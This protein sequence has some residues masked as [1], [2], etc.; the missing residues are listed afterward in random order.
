MSEDF[1][2]LR[3]DILILGSGGAGLLAA[4]HAYDACD[5]LDITIVVKGMFGKSGCTRMVQGG[6]N[7]VLNPEDSFEKHFLDTVKG[8]GF[9]N[10]QELV[11][12]LV[13]HAPRCI[14]ELETK[15]GCFFDR[16]PDGTIHQKPFA[17]QTFDRTVHKGDL[18]GIEIINRLSEQVVRRKIRILEEH[19]ALELLLDASGKTVAGAVV[20]DIQSGK[21]LVVQ[22]KAVLV[23]TGGGPT[24]YKITAASA[25]KSMDGIAMA[26]RVGAELCDMEMVQFHPTGLMAASSLITGT[27]LEEGL[28][29]AGGRLYNGLGERFMEKY[30]PVRMERSTRDIVSRSSYLEIIEGRGSSHSGVFIDMSHLGAAWVERN[31]PGMVKRCRDIGFDL[32]R[33]PVEVSP[34]AHFHM[35][36]VKITPDC[37]SNIPGLFVAGEDAGGVQGANRLGGNGVTE[38][39]VFGS[40]AGDA[41]AAYVKG[42]RHVE[43]NSSQAAEVIHRTQASL[44]QENGSD[45]YNL[46]RE[47]QDLMWEK[48]GLVRDG[49]NLEAAIRRLEELREKAEGIGAP[50]GP[51][52]NRTWQDLLNLRNHLLVCEIIARSALFRPES[53]GSHFRS[54]FPRSDERYIKNIFVRRNENVME[55]YWQAADLSRVRPEEAETWANREPERLATL[56]D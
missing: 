34:T 43:V 4:L 14:L 11:W 46:Q 21:F 49:K 28:R 47:M 54:D 18:T 6:Y 9:L 12:T 26:L 35:G 8:G 23:A 41:M 36:G 15:Y 30:D 13:T 55:L 22:A 16:N 24:M 42:K 44:G 53:R 29:G 27:V 3:T 45:I 37:Q 31:F 32:A 38:S 51:V 40:L 48:A 10:D 7:A 25:D 1:E 5:A 56:R 39:T 19:R 17:G 20:L 33:Q 52:Y 50:G 2:I